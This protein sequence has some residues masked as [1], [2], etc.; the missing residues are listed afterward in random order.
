MHPFK[1]PQNSRF[2]FQNLA[3]LKLA[4]HLLHMGNSNTISYDSDHIRRQIVII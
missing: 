2:P 3:N 4:K 1:P